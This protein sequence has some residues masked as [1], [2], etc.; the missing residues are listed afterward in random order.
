MLGRPLSPCPLRNHAAL[1]RQGI[2]SL[3]P[4]LQAAL[5][6]KGS[7]F[8]KCGY[9]FKY[10][11]FASGLFMQPW[12]MRFFVLRR[13]SKPQGCSTFLIPRRTMGMSMAVL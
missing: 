11:P 2:T 13:V 1:P 4:V 8:I 3:P 6:S 9:L 12:E 5:Q 7:D 10:R